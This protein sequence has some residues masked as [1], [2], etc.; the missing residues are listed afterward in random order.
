MQLTSRKISI[1]VHCVP[2]TVRSSMVEHCAEVCART[3]LAD[4]LRA[5]AQTAYK[6]QKILSRT[7][8]NFE[9]QNNILEPSIIIIII[10]YCI[11]MY[12]YYNYLV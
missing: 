10:N 1:V 5:L 4:F 7:H 2:V 3:D 8:G 6:F 11:I 9:D 12:V